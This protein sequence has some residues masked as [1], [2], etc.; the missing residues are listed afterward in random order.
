MSL[1]LKVLE[2]IQW[3]LRSRISLTVV[4]IILDCDNAD[5]DCLSHHQ[6]EDPGQMERSTEWC[7]EPRVT[8]SSL[9]FGA[10]LQWTCSPLS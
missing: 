6:V 5:A 10:Y 7:L 8:S 4:H 2:I 9:I 1:D 3:C